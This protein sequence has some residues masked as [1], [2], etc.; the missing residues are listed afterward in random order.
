M[1]ADEFSTGH[2]AQAVSI[3]VQSEPDVNPR[4]P[5][6][7]ERCPQIVLNR[8][9]VDSPEEGVAL[10]SDG[11]DLAA[12]LFQECIEIAGAGGMHIINYYFQ[13]CS[14]D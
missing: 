12:G 3:P 10:R 2:Y 4:C 5:C 9:R 11:F 6:K 13:P 7:G 14:A 8:L 1:S